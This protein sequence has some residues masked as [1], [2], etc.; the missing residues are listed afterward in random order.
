MLKNLQNLASES[1]FI[2]SF[3]RTFWSRSRLSRRFEVLTKKGAEFWCIMARK[4]FVS[5]PF[6]EPMLSLSSRNLESVEFFGPL[7]LHPCW[8]VSWATAH[9]QYFRLRLHAC[10][11][12]KSWNVYHVPNQIPNV[13]RN[14]EQDPW[15]AKAAKLQDRSGLAERICVVRIV[16]PPV[17]SSP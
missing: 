2:T 16:P 4:L 1:E 5:H 8:T 6:N 17:Y 14:V 13:I 12:D 3:Y 7:A 15:R 11:L 10:T 9:S